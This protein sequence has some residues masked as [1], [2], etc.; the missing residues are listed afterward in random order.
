MSSA[1]VLISRVISFSCGLLFLHALSRLNESRWKISRYQAK[2]SF[3]EPWKKFC[4]TEKTSTNH[5]VTLVTL[6]C[7][8]TRDNLQH[9]PCCTH[10][11]E[12]EIKTIMYNFPCILQIHHNTAMYRRKRTETN[13]QSR[14][15]KINYIIGVGQRCSPDA[16]NPFLGGR[17]SRRGRT[18]SLTAPR[19]NYREEG[20][21]CSRILCFISAFLWVYI[22]KYCQS[23]MTVIRVSFEPILL[24][25]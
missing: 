11:N 3:Q 2:F 9:Y 25:M 23:I 19:V 4:F 14:N 17:Q 16:L 18:C 22:A 21:G 1:P 15:S 10:K 6:S 24:A 7:C 8:W 5:Q 13:K 12:R 20:C